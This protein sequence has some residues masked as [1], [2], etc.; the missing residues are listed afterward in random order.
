MPQA[1][2]FPSQHPGVQGWE[3]GQGHDL[4]AHLGLWDAERE[5]T[6]GGERR[7]RW[8]WAAHTSGFKP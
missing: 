4:Q 5:R 7:G 8:S 6:P 1:F 2:A 3:G